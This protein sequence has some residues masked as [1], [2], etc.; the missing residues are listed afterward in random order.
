[1]KDGII[2]RDIHTTKKD[3]KNHGFGI[4]SVSA[5]V[6]KYNGFYSNKIE[7]GKFISFIAI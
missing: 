2:E 4:R 3:I 5:V 1:M 7:N 6:D